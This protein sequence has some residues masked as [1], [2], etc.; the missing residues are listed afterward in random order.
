MKRWQKIL[1]CVL[2][3]VIVLA[4]VVG[5]ALGGRIA[6]VMSVKRVAAGIYTMNYVQDYQLDKALRSEL[7]TE[8]KVEEFISK[9]IFFG[10]AINTN[11]DK[12]AC[13]AFLTMNEYDPENTT[14]L[15]GRNFDHY[16]T[17]TLIVRTKAKDSYETISTVAL[18][19]LGVGAPNSVD[20]MSLEGKIAMLAA[21]YLPLDGMNE[22]GL[23]V[24][25]LN[26]DGRE[27][28]HQNT[29]KPDLPITLSVR[30]LLDRAAN[31]GEA[32]DLLKEYDIHMSEGVSQHLFIADTD[33][34]AVVAEWHKGKLKVTESPV[35]TNFLLSSKSM[36]EDP[37]G[38]CDRFDT[39]TRYLAAHPENTP[40]EAMSLLEKVT[41]DEPDYRIVTEWSLVYHLNSFTLD[42]AVDRDYDHVFELSCGAF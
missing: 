30:L 33:G 39:I 18:D 19:M 31:V 34:K 4:A 23:N 40:E 28:V 20:P 13:S 38:I 24:S 15:A 32:V 37:S 9:E 1:L 22:C 42:I 14:Y 29:G 7:D 10:H 5:I 11:F 12:Y 17:D 21:P 25:I 26:V 8:K 35:C 2:A 36:Q 16:Q 3:A 41:I 6:T 27:E